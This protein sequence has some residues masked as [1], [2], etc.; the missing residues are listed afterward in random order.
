VL[1]PLKKTE[2]FDLKVKSKFRMAVALTIKPD[3]IEY[4]KNLDDQTLR[5]DFGQ[6][7]F[8]RIFSTASGRGWFPRGSVGTI[9][10]LE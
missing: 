1:Q 3:S 6:K 8:C 2:N 5:V 7:P 9:W 10:E 4:R